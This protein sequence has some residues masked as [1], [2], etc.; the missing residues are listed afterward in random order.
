MRTSQLLMNQKLLSVHCFPTLLHSGAN[1]TVKYAA[2][3]LG[4]QMK[5]HAQFCTS[6]VYTKGKLTCR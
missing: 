1:K 4:L 5:V 6:P 2:G 3:W